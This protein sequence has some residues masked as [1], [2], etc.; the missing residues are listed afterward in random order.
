M[1]KFGSIVFLSLI[2]VVLTCDAQTK[3][4]TTVSHEIERQLTAVSSLQSL[5]FPHTVSRF[6]RADKF[7]PALVSRSGNQE[8]KWQA[9]LLIDCV[10]QYGLLPS[11]FHPK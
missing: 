4:D 3:T 5:N 11:D 10:L 9:M 2:W 8:A 1:I 6:Y 7:M